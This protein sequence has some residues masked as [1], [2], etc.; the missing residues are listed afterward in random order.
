MFSVVP[1][2]LFQLQRVIFELFSPSGEKKT[3]CFSPESLYSTLSV[4]VF[5]SASSG[6]FSGVKL[7]ETDKVS[8]DGIM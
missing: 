3:V 4:K 6:N 2:L 1:K 7:T 8:V 5:A